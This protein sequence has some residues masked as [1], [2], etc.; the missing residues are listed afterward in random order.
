MS[1]ISVQSLKNFKKVATPMAPPLRMEIPELL[2]HIGAKMFAPAQQNVQS[3]D[4]YFNETMPCLERLH[5]TAPVATYVQ[6]IG[7]QWDIEKLVDWCTRLE[8]TLFKSFPPT[9]ILESLEKNFEHARQTLSSYRDKPKSTENDYDKPDLE[10]FEAILEVAETDFQLWQKGLWELFDCY[11]VA[12]LATQ[13]FIL[14]Y[15]ADSFTQEGI[16]T[17]DSTDNQIANFLTNEA[18]RL[19]NI[20]GEF[21]EQSQFLSHSVGQALEFIKDK[22]HNE[23][24]HKPGITQEPG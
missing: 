19:Y 4:S 9:D 6:N 20:M 10:D 7:Y 5:D 11:E 22:G 3:L 12:Q 1:T 21:H 18:G 24:D 15:Y 14:G 13:K 17:N 23:H 16:N 2:N 8:N